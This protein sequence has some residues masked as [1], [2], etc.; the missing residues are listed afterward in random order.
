[1]VQHL[2]E[3]YSSSSFGEFR[4]TLLGLFSA[5]AYES[6]IVGAANRC[7]LKARSVVQV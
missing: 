3:R 1:V 7:G 5:C 6:N 2:A 4:S